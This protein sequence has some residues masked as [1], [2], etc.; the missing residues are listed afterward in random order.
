MKINKYTKNEIQLA[1]AAASSGG[2]SGSSTTIEG[3]GSAS[4][5]RTIW[6][7][8]DTGDDVDG[9]MTVNGNIHIKVIEPLPDEDDE[10][11][12]GTGEY[13]DYEE[14]GGNLE[15]DELT[16]TKNLEVTE[17]AYIKRHVFIHYPSHPSH[18][19]DKKVCLGEVLGKIEDNV[20]ANKDAIEAEVKRA[21]EA[22]KANKDAIEAESKRA[23]EAEKALD[24]AINDEV[25]RAQDAE[26]ILDKNVQDCETGIRNN[27]EEIA[28]LKNR[29]TAN[30]TAI[31]NFLPIGSIIMFSGTMAEIPEGWA[32]CNGENGTPNL[33]GKFIKAWTEPGVTGGSNSVMLSSSNLPELKLHVDSAKVADN[34]SWQKRLNKYVPALDE[35]GEYVFDKGGSTHYTL[36]TGYNEGDKGLMSVKY[37]AIIDDVVDYTYIGEK[38]TEQTAVPT[39]PAYY[40]LIYIMKVA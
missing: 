26:D 20:K 36:Y 8:Q 30:E 10:D 13:E 21:K 22:E 3:G 15:V 6:G 17:D 35:V 5:D 37:T 24:D 19:E 12:E 7:Q 9:S 1:Q 32:I 39:E 16:K 11:E 27:A 38:G 34:S 40:S 4:L 28:K 25:K 18:P 31:A 23:K 29:T 14:G 33:I 2:G